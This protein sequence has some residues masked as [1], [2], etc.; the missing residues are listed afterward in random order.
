MICCKYK[1]S[2]NILHHFQGLIFVIFKKIHNPG[3]LF[4]FKLYGT[5]N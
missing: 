1:L 2:M 3:T 5:Y 4:L